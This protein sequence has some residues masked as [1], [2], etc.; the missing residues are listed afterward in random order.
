MPR[1]RV[2]AA[3]ILL[4]GGAGAALAQG[5]PCSRFHPMVDAVHITGANRVGT[6]V[7]GAI[8]TVESSSIFR[9]WFNWNLGPYTCLDSTEVASDAADIQRELQLRGFVAATVM[10][11]IARHGDRRAAVT[12]EI[13]EGRPLTITRVELAGLPPG[14][15]DSARAA[16]RLLGLP[17]DDSIVTVFSDSVQG[18][19]RD[20][21]HAR[22][23]PPLRAET[24]D[25]A[26]RTVTERFTFRPG[27]LTYIGA[28]RVHITPSGATPMIDEA[29]V[30]A[31]FAVRAGHAYSARRIADGQRALAA[32]DLYRQ[33]R[34]DTA[35]AQGATGAAR[36][37]IVL[38]LTVVEGDRRRANS[39]AGWGTLDCFRTQTRYVEQ[40]LLG[41]GHRLELNGRL[42]K[43][44]VAE[45]F[46]GLSSLCATRVRND[47]FSQHLNYYAGA[48]VRLRGLLGWRDRPVEPDLS[49][50]SERRSAIGAYEQT[51]DIGAL[52]T[53]T[54]A[55]GS[56]RSVTV[57]VAYTNSRTTADRAVSCTQFGFCRLEDVSSFLQRT[58]ELSETV[59]LVKNPLLPTDDPASGYRWSVEG[60]YGHASIGNAVPIDFGRFTG[61]VASYTPLSS[62]LTLA[63][64]AQVGAV[65]APADR[66]FLLPPAERFYG[67]GQNSVRGYGQNLL[68]PGSYIVPAIDTVTGTDGTLYGRARPDVAFTRIA[69]SGGNAMW[70]GNV[71]LRTRRGWPTDLLRWVVFVDVGR[72]WNTT[73]LFSA[74]NAD[75]R[76]TPG[77]GVRFVTPLGPFRM[78][79]GYNP[80]GLD[81]GPAFF[82]QPGDVA[83]GIAG[84][85]ICV[86][87]GSADPLV[88]GVGQAGAASCPVSYLP[89]RA[90]SLLSRLTFH[91]SLG[92]AF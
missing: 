62:W 53:A 17:L 12:Y 1:A 52:A 10:G 49:L 87:P 22:A 41:L 78:D 63:M 85:A 64:R 77:F 48:T 5:N 23:A 47:P 72:V 66:S 90:S 46:S 9:R 70:L 73:D 76:V 31:A 79:I 51:T 21:G 54:Y 16:R 80:N 84:R 59:T 27:P 65:L 33:V 14:V 4:V 71:E 36:D 91:F 68:G 82:V 40:D 39:S 75:A 44:G 24:I 57:Q 25:S 74:A 83:N 26:R 32:L 34:V 86:S 8:I 3:A 43:I 60:R 81:A 88:L 92:N 7:I 30:R 37:T 58:P 11:R 6:D 45:P 89:P 56:R 15:L 61:E 42:S 67:G 55:L 18:V 2:A 50:F 29:A 38:S 35:S 28:V 19:L 69:P 20:A 13:R